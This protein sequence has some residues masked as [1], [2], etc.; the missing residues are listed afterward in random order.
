MLKF[1]FGFTKV[2]KSRPMTVTTDQYIVAL[3]KLLQAKHDLNGVKYNLAGNS[4]GITHEGSFCRLGDD[5]S[6]MVPWNWQ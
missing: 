5:G 2:T 1:Q 4:L 6:L 3:N